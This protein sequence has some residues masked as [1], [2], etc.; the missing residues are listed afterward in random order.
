MDVIDNEV[1]EIIG[2]LHLKELVLHELTN[3]MYN[4]SADIKALREK[5]QKE[6]GTA[7]KAAKKE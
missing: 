3:D 2:S 1:K 7:A 4:H 5:I 6:I